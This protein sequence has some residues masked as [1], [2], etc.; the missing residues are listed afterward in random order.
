M[1]FGA[2]ILIGLNDGAMGV[3]LPSVIAHYHITTST[4][5]LLFPAS[6]QGYLIAAFNI[7]ALLERLGLAALTF[8]LLA[9]WLWLRRVR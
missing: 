3:L 1:A 5:G 4:V 2:F 6:A 9:L 8:A 7:G